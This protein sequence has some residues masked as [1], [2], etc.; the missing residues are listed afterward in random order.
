[1]QTCHDNDGYVVVLIGSELACFDNLR[2]LHL[3]KSRDPRGIF[4]L[5]IVILYLTRD[6]F[7]SI[8]IDIFSFLYN[9]FNLGEC[10]RV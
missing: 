4:I 6:L 8:L 1:M 7:F 10:Y 5:L 9:M 3:I 2:L